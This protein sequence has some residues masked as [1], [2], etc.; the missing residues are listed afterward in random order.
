MNNLIR[1]GYKFRIYPN[2]KQEVFLMKNF[3]CVRFIYNWGLQKKVEEYTKTKKSPTCIDLIKMIPL[4][5]KEFEWLKEVNPQ[6]L[7][8]SLRNLDNAYTRFFKEKTGFPKFKSK[9]SNHFSFQIPQ[10]V[11]IKNNKIYFTKCTKGIKIKQDRLL[12]GKIKTVTISKNPSNQYFATI[13]LEED[14]NYKELQT[15]DR[16]KTLGIDLGLRHFATLS[17]EIKIENPKYLQKSLKKLQKLNKRHSKKK[18]GSNNRKKH[19]I[20]LAKIYQKISN[21]RSDFLHK[22][23]YK[24][25]H[26]NQVN[27]LVIEDLAISNM[28][29]N[30]HLSRSIQDVSWGEFR[31]QLEYK[32]KWY[33]I[34]FITIGRFDP[35]SKLCS[36]CGIINQNFTLNDRTWT[37]EC[38]KIHDRDINAAINIKNFGVEQYRRN[39]G[40]SSLWRDSGSKQT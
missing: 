34:N 15:L 25:T 30:N 7:Q 31:R 4:L 21:Q 5:K 14:I 20:K 12:N 9:K 1:K 27:S 22:L 2:K 18:L 10:G 38:G 35:S 28:I 26:D 39:Y 29:Q 11:K 19:R 16:N 13:L 33:G 36:N 23:T 32:S 8:M 6:A 17:N 40:N 24:L 3:G 37:C